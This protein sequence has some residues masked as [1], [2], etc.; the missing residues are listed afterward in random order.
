MNRKQQG[1]TRARLR[2]SLRLKVP[3]PT[4]PLFIF[5]T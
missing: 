2:A 4:P 1:E 5:K 3:P